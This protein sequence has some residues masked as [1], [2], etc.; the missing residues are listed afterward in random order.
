MALAGVYNV[1]LFIGNNHQNKV[2]LL[3]LIYG[4]ASH[5]KPRHEAK[6]TAE[7]CQIPV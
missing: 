2:R 5:S 1:V 6:I 7:H 3:Y 4:L